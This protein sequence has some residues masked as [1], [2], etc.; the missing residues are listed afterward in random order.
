MPMVSTDLKIAVNLDECS[1]QE[2][3]S[4]ATSDK[5]KGIPDTAFH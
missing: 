3:A 2:A 4:F 5:W 1:A